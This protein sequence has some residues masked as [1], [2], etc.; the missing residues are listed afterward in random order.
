MSLKKVRGE[1]EKNITE[2]LSRFYRLVPPKIQNSPFNKITTAELQEIM[3]NVA[4][5]TGKRTANLLLMNINSAF[6]YQLKLAPESCYNPAKNVTKFP[7]VER[8]RF[9]TQDEIKRFFSELNK[10]DSVDFIDFIKIAIFTGNRKSNVL[11]MRWKHIDF[12]QKTWIIPEIETKNGKQ[13]YSIL[14]DV[15]IDI[16]KKRRNNK[17]YVFHSSKS[18]KKHYTEPKTAWKTLVKRADIQDLRI[19]DLRRTLASVLAGQNVSL[20]MIANILGQSSTGATPIYARF[21]DQPKREALH[22][23]KSFQICGK[24]RK[25]Y[26]ANAK[27]IN[28]N[29]IEVSS[30]NVSESVEVRYAWNENSEANLYN[31]SGLPTSIFKTK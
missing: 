14:D 8:S 3:I 25:W 9:L 15:V 18:T 19:H 5:S 10:M 31:K 28:K 20:H 23:L 1:K 13:D 21:A 27:I 24:D 22:E 6:N 26:W 17:E 29:Q 12:N 16:L 4:N 7:N 11:S 30:P 2:G